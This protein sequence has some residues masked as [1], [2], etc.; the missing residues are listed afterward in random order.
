[1][2]FLLKHTTIPLSPIYK[3]ILPM[4][5]I[6]QF[7]RRSIRLENYDYSQNGAYF[8]TICTHE[9]RCSFGH[10]DAAG[11]ILNSIG[12]VAYQCWLEIPSHFPTVSLDSFVIMP[13]HV[14]GIVVIT[15]PDL[16]LET[17]IVKRE[18]AKPLP[19]SLSTIVGAFKSAVTKQVNRMSGSQKQSFWQRNY[20][21]HVVRNE[22]NLARLREYIVTNPGKW[23]EDSL[24]S[25]LK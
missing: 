22:E 15:Q 2:P 17:T 24:Y 16:E 10:I 25:S 6:S 11:M 3:S 13:N 23:A 8:V 21:E 7:H 4:T 5:D 19:G 14:H 20:Y 12:T 18:F 1:M 9:R